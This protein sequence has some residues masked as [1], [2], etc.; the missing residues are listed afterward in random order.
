MSDKTKK[1]YLAVLTLVTVAAIIIGSCI[2]ILN[3]FYH[4]KDLFR[5]PGGH[6]SVE[7]GTTDFENEYDS[8]K[9]IKIDCA[10]S[11]VT[12]EE[13]DSFS[14]SF[15]GAERMRPAVSKSDDGTLSIIQDGDDHRLPLK[16]EDN[17]ITITVKE[18]EKLDRLDINLAMGDVKMD[19]VYAS[20]INISAAMGNVRGED[21]VADDIILDA[22]MGNIEFS[23]ADFK[24]LRADAAM[25]SVSVDCKNDL[26][27]YD[28]TASADMGTIKVGGKNVDGKGKYST[29][30]TGVRI[31]SINADC[32]LGNI[33]IR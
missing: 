21:L 30:A 11:E 25:G 29:S 18:A 31:G 7:A 22:A 19:E 20:S 15:E 9:S 33:D 32:D 12:I 8:V 27:A 4:W 1:T 16:D 17:E 3:A 28:I 23:E 2:H 5:L 10:M 13:G 6:E 24:N 26:A 14:V